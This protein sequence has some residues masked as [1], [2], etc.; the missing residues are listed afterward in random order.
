M[1]LVGTLDRWND[2]KKSEERER[3]KHE[4]GDN[5]GNLPRLRQIL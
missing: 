3:V 2:S 1:Y 5:Y 4:G